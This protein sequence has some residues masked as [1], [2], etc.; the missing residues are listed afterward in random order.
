MVNIVK[1][2]LE[3]ILKQIKIA[4]R[5]AA[6]EDLNKLVAEAGGAD[7]NSPASPQAHLQPYGLRTVDGSYN[8]LLPGRTEWGAADYEF[9]YLTDQ[10]FRQGSG[11]FT[12]TSNN[13][14]GVSGDVA[15]AEPRLISNLIVDQTLNNP[16]ALIAALEHAGVTGAAQT[17]AVQE[18][19]Q[20]WQVIKD[21][22]ENSQSYASQKA[23]LDAAL[24]KYGIEMDGPTILLP[25]V[26]PDI[27]DSA[28]Y[29]SM[30]T[31]FGQ[32]FDHGLDLVA[33]GGNGT[34]YIPLSPD[35]PLYNPNSPQTN[36][37][38]MTRASTGED[39][40]NTTTPWVDQNQTYS[41]H[42][43]KQVFMR[44][45]VGGPDGK[46]ANTGDDQQRA[47]K[48]RKDGGGEP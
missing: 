18:I 20:L 43:S 22:D 29:N 31:L 13:D 15:D 17:A 9:K 48:R 7:P 39:A 16:A 5:H 8:N 27:G 4:E 34:V 25:N 26:A 44:E 42:A 41:S 6:G 24:E 33:K 14:Y 12:Y 45:Y 23:L 38:V 11:S 19:C 37:M 36:F 35:D 47:G 32:F 21:L 2:D 10:S 1:H 30:F 28:S 46:P 3:F 40:R